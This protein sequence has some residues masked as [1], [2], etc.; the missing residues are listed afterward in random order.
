L[1]GAGSDLEQTLAP[2]AAAMAGNADHEQ[3]MTLT[4]AAMLLGTIKEARFLE[5]LY[6][7]RHARAEGDE[8]R[9]REHFERALELARSVAGSRWDFR[10]ATVLAYQRR[11][12]EAE[13]IIR[14]YLEQEH[15]SIARLQLPPEL[16]KDRERNLHKVGLLFF[17]RLE[18]AAKA[19][20]CLEALT[21][22]TARIGGPWT[23]R[24]GR[25]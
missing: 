12:A 18:A 21:A 16:Q 22:S 19:E 2:L 15:A 14:R 7:G 1:P 13:A 10:E 5:P 4:M 25:T 3:A 9:A 23:A 20:P 24:R 6:R 8:I 11:N 17:T